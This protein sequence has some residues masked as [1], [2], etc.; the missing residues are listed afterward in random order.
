MLDTLGK[1]KPLKSERKQVLNYMNHSHN[2]KDSQLY[3]MPNDTKSR[4]I[5]NLYW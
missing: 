4:N 3:Q 1:S 5:C 2:S